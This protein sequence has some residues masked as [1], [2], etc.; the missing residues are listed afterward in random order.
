MKGAFEYVANLYFDESIREN[1]NFIV[2][3]LVVS[4]RD[5]SLLIRHHWKSIGQDPDYFEFKSSTPKMGMPDS[6]SQRDFISGIL[7]AETL[8]LLVCPC[9]DRK[10]LSDYCLKLVLQLQRAGLLTGHDALYLDEGISVSGTTSAFEAAKIAI[11]AN[12][13]S[14]VVAGIQAADLAAHSLGSILLNEMGLINKSILF[15]EEAGYSPPVAIP[16]G[17]ELLAD[18]RYTILG[19]PIA[20]IDDTDGLPYRTVEGYGL[21]IAP[22]CSQELA[23]VVKR[24]F[25]KI[26]LGCMH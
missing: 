21:Y 26:Y 10:R 17:A 3:A 9:E 23:D 1:G 5:L 2:G 14:R 11:N 12:C 19:K 22:S 8:G 7:R 13:D 20:D 16:L 25:A 15:G 24:S 6:I 18:L 4:K